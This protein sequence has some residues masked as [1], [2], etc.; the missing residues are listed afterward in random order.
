MKLF[1]FDEFPVLETRRLHLREILTQD[2]EAIFAIRS[3]YE[4]TRLNTGA[5]YTDMYQAHDLIDG[6]RRCY[7]ER[8]ELRWGVTLKPDDT[9][10]GMIGYNYWNRQD[11]RASVGFDLLRAQW[12]KGIMSEALQVVLR[13]GFEH[14]NLNRI[15]ADCSADNVASAGLL[16][17][18]GFQ[19]E[20]VQRQQ[21]HEGGVFY[22]LMLF[23]LLRREWI[24]AQTSR[25]NKFV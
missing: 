2:A 12:R 22:D 14:M 16:K 6:M 17:K 9:V 4:V 3:D 20:G 25:K 11:R 1:N 7:R 5:A 15:E 10:I 8:T 13:F 24:A 23:G 19:Q 21:Y 18:V